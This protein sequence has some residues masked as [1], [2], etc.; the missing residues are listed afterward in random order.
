MVAGKRLGAKLSKRFQTLT[1]TFMNILGA[2]EDNKGRAVPFRPVFVP[3]DSAGHVKMKLV[4]HN[5]EHLAGR[6]R[7]FDG[8]TVG[9]LEDLARGLANVGNFTLIKLPMV[10]AMKTDWTP[11]SRIEETAAVLTGQASIKETRDYVVSHFSKIQFRPPLRDKTTSGKEQTLIIWHDIMRPKLDDILHREQM[12]SAELKSRAEQEA[13][14]QEESPLFKRGEGAIYA[15]F[16]QKMETVYR[17]TVTELK[18]F[19]T[20]LLE[21]LESIKHLEWEG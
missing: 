16:K 20:E 2:P 8:K 13:Y 17:N 6:V 7:S 4:A 21:K 12:R 9:A 18:Q 11:V 15:A 10:V 3:P 1:I 14:T 19:A 5:Q